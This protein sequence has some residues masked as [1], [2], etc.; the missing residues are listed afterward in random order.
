[1]GYY[2][3][4]KEELVMYSVGRAASLVD[5]KRKI[6][7]SHVIRVTQNNNILCCCVIDKNSKI[8]SL[9]YAYEELPFP[10]TLYPKNTYC[11]YSSET[12]N[13]NDTYKLSSTPDNLH[14]K[15]NMIEF[16][17]N[18]KPLNSIEGF[19]K[20]MYNYGLATIFVKK[21]SDYI[22]SIV[23]PILYPDL[24]N[25]EK[26]KN[27]FNIEP[28]GT[29]NPKIINTSIIHDVVVEYTINLESYQP[30]EKL[31]IGI[32]NNSSKK[33]QSVDECLFYITSNGELFYEGSIHNTKSF[34]KE[35]LKPIYLKI[36]SKTSE[37][38]VFNN[39]NILFQSNNNNNLI[40]PEN[41]KGISLVLGI[42][43][44]IPVSLYCSSIIFISTYIYRNI[45][46]KKYTNVL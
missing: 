36:N 28:S 46:I 9:G 19:N 6:I 34:E 7:S 24:S 32:N 23:P 21:K 38:I 45:C 18:I 13:S 17:T 26:E 29:N 12:N 10:I 44:R 5:N 2:F 16:I 41:D 43:G 42:Y 3:S 31:L 8:D 35:L 22:L 25:K 40:Y 20:L 4:P 1:M 11:I 30:N 14:Y 33:V 27:V 37:L 15:N 39:E